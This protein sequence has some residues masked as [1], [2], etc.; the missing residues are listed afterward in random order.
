MR[1]FRYD[2]I[3]GMILFR[4]FAFPFRY[5]IIVYR[6]PLFCLLEPSKL[7]AMA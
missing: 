6:R 7:Y 4:V 5:A 1:H 3:T 2:L